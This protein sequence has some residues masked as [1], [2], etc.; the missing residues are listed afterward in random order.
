MRRVSLLAA[1]VV[2]GC[3][4]EAPR[5]A[6]EFPE[7]GEAPQGMG[8]D[9]GNTSS[10]IEAASSNSGAV[11]AG[12]FDTS[13]LADAGSPSCTPGPGTTG[14][15]SSVVEVVQLINGL[16][17]P[18]TIPCF[19]EAL[20]R[21]LRIMAASSFISA[22]P[23]F[24]TSNPRIF[25]LGDGISL[26]V[27][28]HGDS[29][30]LLEMGELTSNTRSIKAELEFP[31]DQVLALDAAFEHIRAESSQGTVCFGCHHDEVEVVDYPVSGAF[32]SV[33]YRPL[34][35]YEVTFDDLK[36]QFTTCDAGSEPERCAFFDALFAH[37]EV[38]PDRFPDEMPVFQ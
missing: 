4:Q 14:A 10:Q 26:S 36:Y 29:Q 13:T 3:G 17:H 31:I 8:A 32:D 33:A 6:T 21:P 34:P 37:G 18:V 16:P 12:T 11:S 38:L 19:L 30:N 35:N 1:W 27:V 23:A 22:Q 15:P 28:P 25:I 5:Q 9:A 7:L 2:F 24:S 20:E